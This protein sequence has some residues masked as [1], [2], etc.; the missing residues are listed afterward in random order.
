MIATFFIEIFNLLQQMAP[1]LMFGFLIAGILSVFIS[2]SNIQKHLSGKG[3][4][5]IV[6]ASIFGIPLPLCSC[7]VIPVATSLYRKGANKSATT[8][9]LVSTPQTG[10]DSIIL[11]YAFFG[12]VFMMIR[13]ISALI[14]GLLSGLL[15]EII[16][17]GVSD[18]DADC[19]SHK[20]KKHKNV[21]YKV[22]Y[23]AFI[24]L[25][26]DIAKPL[27][28]GMG[29]AALISIF[30]PNDFFIG[31]FD[32]NVFEMISILIISIPLY[33]CATASIPIAA[34][35]MLK[36]VSA[37]AVFVFL[38]AG[39]ATNMATIT[40]IWST[41]GKKSTAIY[42]S[43]VSIIAILTGFIMNTFFTINLDNVM[44]YHEHMNPI[45]GY[46]TSFIF[47]LI[48]INSIIK[49]YPKQRPIT[50]YDLVLQV[51]GMTCSHCQESVINAINSNSNIKSAD[52]D[53]SQSKAYISGLDL[54]IEKIISSIKSSGFKVKK[55]E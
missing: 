52:V 46:T 9:F 7:G 19:D 41:L 21:L 53:L 18:T 55:V 10:I 6:K 54:N 23:Y 14:A 20:N 47:I 8:S 49:F 33:V 31:K 34:A 39:P 45:I 40:T 26:Q 17:P 50:N 36:G 3:I 38:M 12:P 1:Y 11:S 48:L 29:I 28:T 2:P 5:P 13:P 30:I 42:L 22:F 44:H 24:T 27:I 37:G 51:D 16:N 15:T 32:S 4:S 43:S 35:L 25:P